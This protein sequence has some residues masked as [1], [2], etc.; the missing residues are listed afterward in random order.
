[1]NMSRNAV[2]R[3]RGE[4]NFVLLVLFAVYL[5]EEDARYVTCC[6]SLKRKLSDKGHTDNLTG[7][8]CSKKNAPTIV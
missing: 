1:M 4:S 7:T 5:S 6:W 3:R 2:A 8:S